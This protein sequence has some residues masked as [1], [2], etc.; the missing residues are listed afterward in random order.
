MGRTQTARELEEEISE[1]QI[2]Q[3]MTPARRLQLELTK[4]DDLSAS[5]GHPVEEI[6]KRRLKI[7][8]SLL[9]TALEI[10][11]QVRDQQSDRF[12]KYFLGWAAVLA[13]LVFYWIVEGNE[14]AVWLSVAWIGYG[15]WKAREHNHESELIVR[16]NSLWYERQKE[17]HT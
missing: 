12:V 1:L 11:H 17:P 5:G 14:T 13:G 16:A 7:I 4:L 8:H 15:I 6:E 9:P 2:N 3:S 10:E